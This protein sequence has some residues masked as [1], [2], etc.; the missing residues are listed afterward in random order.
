MDD[1]KRK[2]L[3]SAL[4]QIEK[5]F[6]KG[7]VMRM[8]DK[9][10]EPI[11]AVSTGSFALDMALG[12]GGL[13]RGRVVEI[14]GP[15]S[16]GKTTLTLQAIASCQKAGGTAAFVDAE[17]ALDPSYAEK[18]GVNVDDLLVSQ[19]DTGEQALEITDMLVRSGAVDM[20]VI[21]SVAAL[22]PKAEIEG[23]MGEMQVGLQARLMSQALR[24]LTGTIKKSGCLVI[25]INQLRM[26][27]GNMM[28]G[29]NPETTTGGNA[30][31]FYA[32]VRLDIRRIGSVKK[33]DEIIGNETK[34]KVVKNKLAPP[35]KQVFTEILY[36]EGISRE[37]ELIDLGVDHKLVEKSGS[38][39]SYG[40]ERIGQGKDNARNFLKEHKDVAAQIE[41]QLR[42]KMLPERRAAS[43]PEFEPEEA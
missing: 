13:P 30:L 37:S 4:S 29:Q 23:E 34:I 17:H 6:G 26:K 27:I 10:A 43:T 15:E 20:V 36:G 5:Q 24:K 2:A 28:P 8:G 16:S 41:A 21:D 12:I 11:D 31:K 7:T 32:S 22:T 19:P 1:N 9:V 38:W 39:Y 3:A 33:G 14:Y 25:F 35:F 42:I 40:G 18:L